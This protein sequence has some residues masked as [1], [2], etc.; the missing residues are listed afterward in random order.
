MKLSLLFFL[1]LAVVSADIPATEQPWQ[2]GSLD[3]R[4]VQPRKTR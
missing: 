2:R 4:Q 1:A 3:S